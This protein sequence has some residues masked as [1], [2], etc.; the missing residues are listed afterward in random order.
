MHWVCQASRI[1]FPAV[2]EAPTVKRTSRATLNR[3]Q[4]FDRVTK[5]VRSEL[6]PPLS[7]FRHRSNSMLL[8]IDY[9]NERIHFEVWVDS[10]RDRIEI[11]LHFEDGPL[12]TVAYLAFFDSR[13]VEIKHH[14][15]ARFELER[16]TPSWGHLFESVP[17]APLEPTFADLTARRLAAQI[18]LLQP[19]VEEAAIPAGER[20]FQPAARRRWARRAA[21]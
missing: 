21:S 10:L 7:A 18:A 6:P 2:G 4:F 13:I 17:L 14:L 3:G 20:T 11:G 19:M 15:G 5:S 8:K 12:S 1:D 16:W 9:G